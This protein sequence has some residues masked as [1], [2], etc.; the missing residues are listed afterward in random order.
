[1]KH[2]WSIKPRGKITKYYYCSQCGVMVVET[3]R[4]KTDQIYPNCSGSRIMKQDK[5]L[6]TRQETVEAIVY[7]F[8]NPITY[9][10]NPDTGEV[11]I[12]LTE[13]AEQVMINL[14]PLI[15]QAFKEGVDKTHK[16]CDE[17]YGEMLKAD[18]EKMLTN[19]ILEIGRKAVE[20]VLIE[21]RDGRLS[22]FNKGN[23]LVIRE[24]DGKDSHI[25]RFGTE[26]AL[27]IGIKAM[28]QALKGGN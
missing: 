13:T 16:A 27:K 18:K 14:E 10:P 7:W 22:M 19:E 15:Q 12:N 21:W 3:S 11:D 25:I 26:T 9:K 6:R 23:G 4:E 1:M 24:K 8:Q 5:G 20:D 17:T 2:R 28:Y